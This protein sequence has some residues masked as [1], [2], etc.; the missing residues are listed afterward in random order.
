MNEGSMKARMK[1][2]VLS[3]WEKEEATMNKVFATRKKDD[4]C[5]NYVSRLY[6]N[7]NEFTFK[8][9]EIKE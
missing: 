5:N 3:Q 8:T 7:A 2:F 4:Q 6:D 9:N 1:F